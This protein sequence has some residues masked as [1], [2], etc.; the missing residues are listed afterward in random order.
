[1]EQAALDTIAA[2]K[3]TGDLKAMTSIPDA[4]ALSTEQFILAI[5]ETYE[6]MVG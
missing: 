2:G 6:R 4:Q 5:R 1:M 3:M